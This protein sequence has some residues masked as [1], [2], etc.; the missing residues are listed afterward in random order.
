MVTSCKVKTLALKKTSSCMSF[1]HTSLR[2]AK[3]I[4]L[5][6]PLMMH[7]VWHC[8]MIRWGLPRIGHRIGMWDIGPG[9]GNYWR[10]WGREHSSLTERRERNSNSCPFAGHRRKTVALV[11]DMEGRV[12]AFSRSIGRGS[13]IQDLFFK[14]RF[15]FCFYGCEWE[16]S[17]TC[18]WRNNLHFPFNVDEVQTSLFTCQSSPCV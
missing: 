6:P 17:M 10:M 1:A 8:Y 14:G 11:Q 16:L 12:T 5:A 7:I 18:S 13:P 15:L 9:K 3:I 4:S 2:G